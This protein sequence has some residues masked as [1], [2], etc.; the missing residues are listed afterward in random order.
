MTRSFFQ[1]LENFGV[2]YLLI[3]GQATVLYGAAAFSED[4]D[5]W[6]EPSPENI[7]LLLQALRS[8]KARYYKLTPSLTVELMVKGHGFHFTLEEQS[9]VYI[10]IL[11]KPPRVRGFD[12]AKENSI[13]FETEWGK[14]PVIGLRDLVEVKKTQ[15]IEDYSIISRLA[16]EW[17]DRAECGKSDADFQWAL[18]NIFT[19]EQLD[20]FTRHWGDRLFEIAPEPLQKY[21]RCVASG[22]QPPAEF[23]GEIS[24]WMQNRMQKLQQADRLYWREIVADLRRLKAANQLLTVGAVV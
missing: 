20:I 8:V 9:T 10:D 7:D 11:G 22:D 15:R 17:L 2:P 14:I 16:V 19:L 4:I 3:S 12:W 13:L 24:A 23:E 6:V 18:D 5:L 1:S 21:V